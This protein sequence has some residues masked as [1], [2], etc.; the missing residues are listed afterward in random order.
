MNQPHRRAGAA[1]GVLAALIGGCQ[2]GSRVITEGEKYPQGARH[3]PSIDIQVFRHDTDI[4][5]TNTTARAFGPSTIWLN[6]R[7]SHRIDGLALGQT[8]KLPLKSFKDEFG[9]SF[10]G[11]GFFATQRPEYLG[12]AELQTGSEMVG[13]VVVGNEEP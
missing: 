12:L 9:E 5:F 8:L 11:G 13:L 7:F 1:I 2:S 6:G 4:E 10:R 3:G